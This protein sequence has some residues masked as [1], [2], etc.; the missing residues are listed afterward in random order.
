MLQS[1]SWTTVVSVV[2]PHQTM[3]FRHKHCGLLNQIKTLSVVGKPYSF[4]LFLT[5]FVIFLSYYHLFY[6]SFICPT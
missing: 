3:W 5:I 4:C 1:G 2:Y 6:F